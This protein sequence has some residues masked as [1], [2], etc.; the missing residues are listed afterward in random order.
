VEEASRVFKTPGIVLNARRFGEGHT[1][2]TLMTARFGKVDVSAFG[3]RKPGS[4]LASG[5]ETFTIGEMVMAKRGHDKPYTLR[6]IDV[7]TH[8]QSIR[9]SLDRYLV[10]SAMIEPY[11]RFVDRAHRDDELYSLLEIC[12]RLLG[13]C[14]DFRRCM[15]LLCAFDIHFLTRMGYRP[16][17]SV[18]GVCGRP[19]EVFF[20]DPE[21][22]FPVCGSCRKTESVAVSTGAL[23]FVAWTL[24]NPISDALRAVLRQ[25]TLSSLRTLVE[26][27]YGRI[28]SRRVGSWDF[29][30]LTTHL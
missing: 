16:D 12:L 28:F 10:G 18:C 3:A 11:L 2:V 5:I 24:E 23:E 30:D 20:A 21:E 17:L 29:L 8:N 6:E 15:G 13:A 9:D 1:F 22:G 27:S 19:I 7:T 26:F 25:E 4:R 14:P